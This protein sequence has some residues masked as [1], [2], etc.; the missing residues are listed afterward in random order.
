[1]SRNTADTRRTAAELGL[2]DPVDWGARSLVSSELGPISD[3]KHIGYNYPTTN[4]SLYS[5]WL[6]CLIILCCIFWGPPPNVCKE[7]LAQC[8]DNPRDHR[9]KHRPIRVRRESPGSSYLSLIRGERRREHGT[10]RLTHL[11]S[12]PNIELYIIQAHRESKLINESIN[13]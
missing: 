1:M 5:V 4:F 9:S 13:Q 10:P 12:N 6:D 3:R 7:L 2:P 8:L 11:G